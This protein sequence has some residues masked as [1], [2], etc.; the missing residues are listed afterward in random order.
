[1]KW[2]RGDVDLYFY[3]SISNVP[4]FYEIDPDKKLI[5][6]KEVVTTVEHESVNEAGET[7]ITSE[8]VKT[9][10]TDRVINPVVYCANGVIIK[11]C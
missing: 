2:D 6:K 5:I 1:M 11:P 3:P 10:E 8:E 7:V 9:Y 4:A